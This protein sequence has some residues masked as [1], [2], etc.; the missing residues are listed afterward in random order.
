MIRLSRTDAS[1]QDFI[2][3]VKSLD[4]YLKISDGDEHEF[5][6]QYNHLDDIKY[7]VLAYQNEE[8]VACGAIKAYDVQTMEVKRMFVK[9]NARGNGIA[10]KLLIELQKWTKELGYQ[11]CILETGIH[12]KAAVHLYKKSDYQVIPNYGQYAGKALSVCME[13]ILD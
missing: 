6:H 8:A 5:Y 3:L 10:S 1:N 12:Q 9:T 2:E 7:V 13:K 11:K 4:A